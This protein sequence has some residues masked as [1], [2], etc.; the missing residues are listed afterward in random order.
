M[1]LTEVNTALFRDLENADSRIQ[2]DEN[3]KKILSNKIIL[4]WILKYAV[5]EFQN[6]TVDDIIK[7]IEGDPEIS[8]IPI[9]PGS[10]VQKIAGMATEDAIP[11]EGKICFDI[12]FK[13]ITPGE[14]IT[15]LLI[16]VE[17]QKNFYPGYDLV[18]R[19]IFYGARMISAQLDIEFSTSC[20]DDIKKVYSIWI[21]MSTPDYAKNSITSYK[22]AKN[23]KVGTN[24]GKSRYDLL[25]I[26]MIC[27]GK[28]EDNTE[29]ELINMLNVLLSN[30]INVQDKKRILVER[31]G[32][33]ST[34]KLDE[35]M[36]QMCNL[37]DLVY[38]EAW[39]K[40]MK[41]GMKEGIERGMEKGIEEGIEQG[42]ERGIVQGIEKRA[43]IRL[44]NLVDTFVEKNDIS[45]EKTLEMFSVTI[46]EYE[47]AKALLI[48]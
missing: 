5:Y 4:A 41:A 8:A 48:E 35:E 47:T 2:Y 30:K 43:A 12:R 33:N 18:T 25:E 19:G 21:C 37:S 14:V 7:L 34:I 20:Y 44:I 39:E 1:L 6:E 26:V 16:N 45:F 23:P 28:A 13:A 31:F 11:N 3:V 17:A 40:G 29:S 32:I 22:I 24:L 38:E 27:L 36:R 46:A 10:N 15:K 9:H 42:I